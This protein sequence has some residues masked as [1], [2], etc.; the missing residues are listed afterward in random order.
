MSMINEAHHLLVISSN[1]IAH[2]YKNNIKLLSYGAVLLIGINLLVIIYCN[3]QI[4]SSTQ[5]QVFSNIRD[6]PKNKVG[7]LLGTSKWLTTGKPNMYFKYRIEAAVE[8]YRAGKIK[9]IVVSGDNR[10]IYY[11]EPRDMK[12]ELIKYGI[13]EESIYLDYA[14]FRTLDSVI[15]CNKIFGQDC[16]TIISQEFHNRRAIYIA[17]QNGIKTIGYN[18]KDVNL[19]NDFKTKLREKLARVK[20]FIDLNILMKQPKF[21]GEK[22]EIK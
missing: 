17:E 14:G 11:N 21:L 6:L 5:D 8:L 9:Y 20:V 7:L 18:A 10:T 1:K 2:F 15:R 4:E 22:V 19:Y 3:W 16:F 13:P 12:R